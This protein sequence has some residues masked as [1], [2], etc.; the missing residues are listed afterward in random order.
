MTKRGQNARNCAIAMKRPIHDESEVVRCVGQ[1]TPGGRRSVAVP[2]AGRLPVG[3]TRRERITSMKHHLVL[4]L[5][6]AL[7]EGLRVPDWQT[8]VRD[9]SVVKEDLLPDVDRLLHDANAA[10]WVTREY[11]PARGDAWTPDEIAHRL[12]RTYRLILQHDY[13]LPPDLV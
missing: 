10:F 13:A 5:R 2:E 9:K 6:A 4:T 3:S 1:S 7:V 11:R 12:D 8:F